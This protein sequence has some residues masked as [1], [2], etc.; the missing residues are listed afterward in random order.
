MAVGTGLV[1]HPMGGGT[2]ELV[3]LAGGALGA[4]VVV[5]MLL[6]RIALMPLH[7]LEE[8]ARRVRDGDFAARVPASPL[9]DRD[10]AR[11][12]STL[13]LLLDRLTEDRTR[14]RQL[15][16]EVISAG[17]RERARIARDLHDSTAQSLAA[18]MLQLSAVARDTRDRDPALG[19]RLTTLKDTASEVLEEVRTLS[20]VVHPRVLDDLGL[21]A[22][23]RNLA[24][25][26]ESAAGEVAVSVAADEEGAAS[27]AAALD[28]ATASV[29]YRVAQEAV[30]NAIRH[31]LPRTVVL[32]LTARDGRVTLEVTDDGRGFD[33]AE[34]EARRPGMGLFTMRERV[35][36]VDGR[37]EVISRPGAGTT[38]RATV[39][40]GDAE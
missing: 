26:A 14:A 11:V 10:M 17:E 16:A 28:Q 8:T 30:G 20:H 34:A 24:R 35:S 3:A 13:N 37:F 12:G 27:A 18:L 31:A 2:H 9:A 15:A 29:L 19:E 38:V 36:L 5:S 32:G 33:V 22:A 39:A 25:G 40:A 7:E 23:R 1:V 4:G 6:V 21:V